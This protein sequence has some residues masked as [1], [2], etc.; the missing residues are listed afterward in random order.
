M[1]TG[2]I[3]RAVKKEKRRKS[4]FYGRGMSRPR[5]LTMNSFLPRRKAG[6]GGFE[7]GEEKEDREKEG[8]Q[9]WK[10]TEREHVA[11]SERH[12]SGGEMRLGEEGCSKGGWREKRERW[13]EKF[14]RRGKLPWKR[15]VLSRPDSLG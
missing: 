8:G 11:S 10:E 6:E 9:R 4:W 13:R 3:R 12:E 7:R 15:V 14:D 5:V 2:G 1:D